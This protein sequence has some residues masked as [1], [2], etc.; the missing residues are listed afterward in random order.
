MKKHKTTPVVKEEHVLVGV[1]CDTCKKEVE[2]DVYFDVTTS[3]GLWGNDSIDSYEYL[4]FC[5]LDCMKKHMDEHFGET[6]DTM[7]Y[8][9]EIEKTPR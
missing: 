1:I 7:K 2:G 3:H 4:D 5:S 9:I 6:R 8:E